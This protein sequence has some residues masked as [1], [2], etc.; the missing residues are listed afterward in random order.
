MVEGLYWRPG[1]IVDP[2]AA[3]PV[4]QILRSLPERCTRRHGQLPGASGTARI[5]APLARR[6]DRVEV[7]AHRDALALFEYA[8]HRLV[9]GWAVA[10]VPVAASL[11]DAVHARVLGPLGAGRHHAPISIR[12]G[13]IPADR[14]GR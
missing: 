1:A 2:P 4:D 3:H 6:L 8:H 10:A 9:G 14:R 5:L 11:V 12:C 13:R 7:L